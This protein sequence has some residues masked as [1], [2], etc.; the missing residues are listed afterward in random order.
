MSLV[1]GTGPGGR[2]T[3]KDVL[4]FTPS[5]N[6]TSSENDTDSKQDIEDV[7]TADIKE[8]VQ[9]PPISDATTNTDIPISKDTGDKLPLSRMRQ[10]I[11]RVT[12]Q[13][14]QQTPH[15]YVSTEINMTEA[16]DLRNQI[17]S[18][19]ESEGVRIS[20]NDLVIKACVDALNLHPKF[21]ASFKEDG[22]LINS[23][24]NIGIAIAE[25]EGLIVPAIMECNNKSV[26]DISTASKD[27]VARS[28]G[29]T[30]R[31]Q[32]YTEGTFSISNLGMFDVSSFIAIILPP[33]SAMLAVGS[34]AEQAI[35]KD[36][37]VAVAKMMNAT[38]SADHR[39]TDG[40][41][42]AKFILDI[43]QRLENPMTLVI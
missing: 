20:V 16:M 5:A 2:I 27:L 15:Y 40:A 21:N 31:P 32:E 9:I 38:L 25:E 3:K 43:K 41:E 42:G 18:S 24:I 10:Q 23:S 30:L 8:P 35:V 17:N 34:V 29:G 6:I 4:S 19:L 14:K 39:V 11:A 12:V 33:Q 36:G 37:D 7:S 26:K 13:S 22:V 28:K 1:K